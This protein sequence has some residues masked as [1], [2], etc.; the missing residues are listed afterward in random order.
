MEIDKVYTLGFVFDRTLNN[1]LMIFKN[2]GQFPG[3]LNGIGGLVKEEE[4]APIAFAR[5]LKDEANIELSD[6]LYLHELVTLSFYH[7]E[8]HTFGVVLKEFDRNLTLTHPSGNVMWCDVKEIL[9]QHNFNKVAGRGDV[10]FIIRYAIE[11]FERVIF[12][13][14]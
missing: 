10:Q 6:V 14:G 12:G 3:K 13:M 4:S 7:E 2:N 1:V 9:D 5:K 8:V 11:Q